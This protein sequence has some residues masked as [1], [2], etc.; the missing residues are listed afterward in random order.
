MKMDVAS[1]E[2]AMNSLDRYIPYMILVVGN[3]GCIC[4]FITFT[5]KQL[6]SNSCGWYFLMSA[7]F[8]FTSINLGLVTKISTDK[9]GNKLQNQNHAWCR[10]R[11]FLTWTLPCIATGYVLLASI[12]RCLSTSQSTGL[13]SFSQIK[14][15]HRMTCVPI[16]LYSLTNSHQLF[17]YDLRPNCAAQPGIYSYFLSIYSLFWTSLIP[18]SSMFIFAI[19][20][21]YNIKKSRQRLVNSQNQQRNRTN[22]QLITITFFQVLCTSI[23]LNIRTAYFAYTNFS[24]DLFKDDYRLAIE[25]LILQMTSYIFYL[26]FSK[27][28]FVNTLSSKLFRQVFRQRSINIFYQLT[29]QVNRIHPIQVAAVVVKK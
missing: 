9:Y 25:A 27:S 3:F 19:I 5:S 22:S 6:R 17:Y 12:D 13:R 7:I 26:N 15:A 16:I 28:F 2:A 24:T 4:N 21:Y 8:D 10:I 20:T 23:L 14:V 29:C 1:I 18:Q 11:I